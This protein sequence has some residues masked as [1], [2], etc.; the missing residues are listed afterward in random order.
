MAGSLR[1]ELCVGER[2]CGLHCKRA[3][4]VSVKNLL[5]GGQWLSC[6]QMVGAEIGRAEPCPPP[7]LSGGQR[8]RTT[9]QSQRVWQVL[10]AGEQGARKLSARSPEDRKHRCQ[11]DSGGQLFLA[12][13]LKTLVCDIKVLTFSV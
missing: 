10:G 7:S 12:V 5:G 1:P 2:G 3:L 11:C 6:L 8:K 4:T 9:L 13:C